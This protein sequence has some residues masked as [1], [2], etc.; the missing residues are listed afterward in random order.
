MKLF[1]HRVPIWVNIQNKI[2][3]SSVAQYRRKMQCYFQEII[4]IF[5]KTV[6]PSNMKFYLQR[7]SIWV[8]IQNKFQVPQSSS[9]GEKSDAIL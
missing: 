2:S 4:A 5:S 1:L 7:V 8:N 6:R 9:I 3:S